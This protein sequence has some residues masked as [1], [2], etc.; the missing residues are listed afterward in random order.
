M[1]PFETEAGHGCTRK[2]V[3]VIC[4]THTWFSETPSHL[5]QVLDTPQTLHY[6]SVHFL[7]AGIVQFRGFYWALLLNK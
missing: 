6:R 1:E 4:G 7:G 5:K 3:E 2:E